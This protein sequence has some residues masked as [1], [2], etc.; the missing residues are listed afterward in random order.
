MV[1]I[2]FVNTEI[3]RIVR[4]MTM[5]TP[6]SAELTD[7]SLAEE[8]NNSILSVL[9]SHLSNNCD[10]DDHHHHA[11]F[12][13]WLLLWRYSFA[14]WFPNQPPSSLLFDLHND[15]D[16]PVTNHD[17]HDHSTDQTLHWSCISH[18]FDDWN[19][20]WV[21]SWFWSIPMIALMNISLIIVTQTF[22]T[23]MTDLMGN[24]LKA[25]WRPIQHLCL[26]ILRAAIIEKDPK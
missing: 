5:M 4:M 3:T 25:S 7:V 14:D 24:L 26:T 18:L 22:T 9:S 15:H 2:I 21:W 6:F 19:L 1:I 13:D 11:Q 12:A 23:E 10:D 8:D 17:H 16:W 20:L